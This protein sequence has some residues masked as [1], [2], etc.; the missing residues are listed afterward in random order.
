MH[1]I[2]YNL[3]ILFYLL[4]FFAKIHNESITMNGENAQAGK[5]RIETGKRG[6]EM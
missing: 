6:D 3:F 4:I 2:K 5:L 1:K